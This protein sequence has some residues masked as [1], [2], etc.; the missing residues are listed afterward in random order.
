M[1]LEGKLAKVQRK[2]EEMPRA[3]RRAESVYKVAVMQVVM[4]KERERKCRMSDSKYRKH[5]KM[6]VRIYLTI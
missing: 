1:L 2:G 6:E 5:F 3:V 4:D